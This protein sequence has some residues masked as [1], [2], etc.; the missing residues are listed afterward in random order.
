MR[1]TLSKFW[2]APQNVI[3]SKQWERLLQ[4]NSAFREARM[5]KECGPITDPQL[6]QSCLASFDQD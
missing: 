4:T 2:S 3:E 1:T 5:C 6:H